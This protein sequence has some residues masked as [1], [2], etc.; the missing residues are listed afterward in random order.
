MLLDAE[1][2]CQ[3][4]P[5]IEIPAVDVISEGINN[6]LLVPILGLVINFS[7]FGLLDLDIQIS[8]RIFGVMGQ[9]KASSCTG[10]YRKA[11]YKQAKSI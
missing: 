11:T 5:I 8:Y 1:I 7:R 4:P 6:H 2:W 3:V 10:V 9:N